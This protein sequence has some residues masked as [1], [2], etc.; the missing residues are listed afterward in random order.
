MVCWRRRQPEPQAIG[1]LGREPARLVPAHEGAADLWVHKQPVQSQVR[2]FR[3]LLRSAVDGRGRDTE[4]AVRPPHG[5]ASA[6]ALGLCG[7]ACEAVIA[8]ARPLFSRAEY[9]APP[10]MSAFTRVFDAL[11]G[12]S[13]LADASFGDSSEWGRTKSSLSR[14]DIGPQRLEL[15]GLEEVAPRRHLVLA[16]RHRIDE[17]FTLVGRKFPQIECRTGLLHARAVTRRAVDGVEL[18]TGPDL[19]LG[20]ALRFFGAG[21]Y[22]HNEACQGDR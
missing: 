14:H 9:H 2:D 19:V 7:D 21:R 5:H 6:A 1:L 15:F 16:A 22:A 3:H 20:E 13:I 4:R 18:G 11:C 8:L 10:S 12:R 17:A